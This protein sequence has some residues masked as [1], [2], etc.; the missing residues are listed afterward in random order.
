M[1]ED[2]PGAA[3]AVLVLASVGASGGMGGSIASVSISTAPGVGLSGL[4][5]V[6]KVVGLDA[7][8]RAAFGAS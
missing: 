5:V 3:W 7:V 2:W 8:P 6:A 4:G 1:P